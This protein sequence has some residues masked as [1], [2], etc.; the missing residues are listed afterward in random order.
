MI[1][2]IG[3]KKIREKTILLI[4]RHLKKNPGKLVVIELGQEESRV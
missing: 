3:S 2:K 1:G 4:R